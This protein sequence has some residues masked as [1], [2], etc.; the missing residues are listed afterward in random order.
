MISSC[1]PTSFLNLSNALFTAK[2][3]SQPWTTAL[4]AN[5]SKA[6]APADRTEAIASA[7]TMAAPPMVCQ[8]PMPRTNLCGGELIMNVDYGRGHCVSFPKFELW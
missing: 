8:E 1:L 2:F 7:A 6:G 5:G 4:E 3:K